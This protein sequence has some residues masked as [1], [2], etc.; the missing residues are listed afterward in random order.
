MQVVV[1]LGRIVE[2]AGALSK[3]A[4]HDVFERFSFPLGSFDEV[5]GVVD[6]GQVMLVVVVF[7][8]LARHVGGERVILVRK[9]G[10]RKRHRFAP[11][12][13]KRSGRGGRRS[14]VTGA[15]QP[16]FRVNSLGR[17]GRPGNG[18]NPR[19]ESK[20]RPPSPFPDG[21]AALRAAFSPR[22]LECIGN[23]RRP[24]S[25]IRSRCRGLVSAR[26]N[27]DGIWPRPRHISYCDRSGTGP[28]L[29]SNHSIMASAED[30]G[31][32]RGRKG[33]A[34]TCL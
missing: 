5:V 6:I 29:F 34:S 8:R 31:P 21:G 10:Q 30:G 9:V 15:C 25:S 19:F 1:V 32:G 33:G 23:E 2:E 13:I 3:R 22:G 4:F 26:I 18:S 24:L 12:M 14:I 28:K 27:Q 16:R 20:R 7:E 11:Q 17:S